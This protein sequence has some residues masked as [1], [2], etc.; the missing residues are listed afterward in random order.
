MFIQLPK[1]NINSSPVIF[2]D[3]AYVLV[4]SDEDKFHCA[5]AVF[6]LLKLGHVRAG[7]VGSKGRIK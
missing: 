1:P 3:Y 5:D 7:D 2:V 6:R 4:V